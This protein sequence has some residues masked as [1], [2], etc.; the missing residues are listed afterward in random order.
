MEYKKDVQTVV[1]T[2]TYL[3]IANKLLSEEERADIVAMLAANPE[4]GNLIR[5]TGGF[6]K[7]RVARKGMGKSGGA[8][9]V[10]IWRNPRFPVFLITVFAKNQKENLSMAERNALRKRANSIFETYGS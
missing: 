8:R 1:E 3:A 9:V 6:R 7:V 10:Y 2:P 4:C 5:G